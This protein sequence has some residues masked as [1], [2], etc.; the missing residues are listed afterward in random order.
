MRK[1]YK[2]VV[3]GLKN[4]KTA[5]VLITRTKIN[6]T[7]FKPQKLTKK[8]QVHNELIELKVGDNVEIEESK[9]F[10]ATKKFI[11]KRIIEKK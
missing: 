3:V 8:I 6:P 1:V 9:V 11:V 2:G 10:S 7:Y 5:S 4:L